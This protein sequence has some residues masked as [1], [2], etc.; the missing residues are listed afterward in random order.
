MIFKKQKIDYQI[1]L[2]KPN[3]TTAKA[4]LHLLKDLRRVALKDAACAFIQNHDDHEL[5]QTSVFKKPEFKQF[6]TQMETYLKSVVDKGDRNIDACLVGVNHRFNVQETKLNSISETTNRIKDHMVTKTD[7]NG[8]FQ[9]MG[10]Y[11]LGGISNDNQIQQTTN[12]TTDN[13]DDGNINNDVVN[14]DFY[15]NHTSAKSMWDEWYGLGQFSDTEIYYEGGIANL[16]NK[17]KNKWKKNYSNSKK[18]RFS[19]LNGA[20]KEIRELVNSSEDTSVVVIEKLDKHMSEAKKTN[21][22][23]KIQPSMIVKYIKDNKEEI[24]EYVI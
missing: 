20:T 21:K 9:Y 23:I 3:Q 18:R 11:R 24:L 5:F 13:T 19:T 2:L 17:F 7:V 16:N 15:E 10:D 8:I 14:Y 12:S 6:T 4:F 22:R 1:S